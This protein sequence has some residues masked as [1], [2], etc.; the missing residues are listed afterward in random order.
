MKREFYN[1]NI[2][3]I[4][5]IGVL[6][7][8]ASIVIGLVILKNVRDEFNLRQVAHSI[9]KYK[10]AFLSFQN[11]YN[12]LPGDIKNANLYFQNPTNSGNGDKKIQ[13]ENGEAILAWQ[14][15]QTAEMLQ[16]DYILT[17]KWQDDKVGVNVVKVNVPGSTFEKAGFY[18]DYNDFI[19]SNFI[20]FGAERKDGINDAPIFSS[21]KLRKLDAMID[22]GLPGSGN[23]L[24]IAKE[25]DKCFVFGEYKQDSGAQAECSVMFKL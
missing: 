19:Q 22:D 21:E 5:I 6:I 25:R 15:L 4:K 16:F 14:H 10:F 12:G 18:F 24:G 11:I 8:T 17:G 20:G 13:H 23:I 2:S 9:N 7:I 3:I 1:P